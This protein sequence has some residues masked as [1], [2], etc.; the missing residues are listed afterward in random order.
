MHN[1]KEL[2]NYAPAIRK[3]FLTMICQMTVKRLAKTVT[4][5]LK[6]WRWKPFWFVSSFTQIFDTKT[7]HSIQTKKC[8]GSLGTDTK[9]FTNHVH[10]CFG[11]ELVGEEGPE[12]WVKSG[13]NTL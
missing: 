13:F 4:F 10:Y 12:T 2:T 8:A 11:E 9:I 6:R 7:I 5:F 3:S 1:H